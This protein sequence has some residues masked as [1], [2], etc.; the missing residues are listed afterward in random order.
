[1]HTNTHHMCTHTHKHTHTHINTCVCIHTH[2]HKY[3]HARIHTNYIFS[4]SILNVLIDFLGGI[5]EGVFHIFTTAQ[6]KSSTQDDNMSLSK[7]SLTLRLI[8]PPP[9]PHPP[10]SSR[11]I[12]L[13]VAHHAIDLMV[14]WLLHVPAGCRTHP[15]DPSAVH[16]ITSCH[17]ET[18]AA[19]QTGS[20][21]QSQPSIM[22]S[23]SQMLSLPSTNSKIPARRISTRRISTALVDLAA[24]TNLTLQWIPARK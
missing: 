12:S 16:Q 6:A 23:S 13:V 20:L 21:M 7:T 9:P 19:D 3:A 18:D 17:T 15:R 22:R 8:P 2:T 24:Y 10:T 11:F 1:M 14:S 5:Q 4:P